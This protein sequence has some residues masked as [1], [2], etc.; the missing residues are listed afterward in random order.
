MVKRWK[1]AFYTVLAVFLVF[2]LVLIGLFYYFF[3]PAGESQLT[4]DHG[5]KFGEQMFTASTTKEQV[6]RLINEQLQSYDQQTN[7]KLVVALEDNIALNGTIKI[8]ESDIAFEMKFKPVAQKNGDLVLI[9]D[10][11]RLGRVPLPEDK[12]L[13]FIK[14][15]TSLPDWVQVLPDQEK[16]YV[17]LTEIE[18]EDQFYL[19]AKEINLKENIIEFLVYKIPK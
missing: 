6:E 2:I 12:V 1:I 19:K 4:I 9:E 17:A 8:F 13:E 14:K 11:F 7:L 3:P 16:I 5:Q 10:S 18:L 15:G